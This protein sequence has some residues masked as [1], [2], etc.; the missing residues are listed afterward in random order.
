[1]SVEFVHPVL[2]GKRALP[3]LDISSGYQSSLRSALRDVDIVMGF[4]GAGG[5]AAIDAAIVESSARGALTIA[6]PGPV[7]DYAVAPTSID[8][9][10]QQ[11]MIEVLY[12]AL[13]ETVHLFL[14]GQSIGS[15][16]GAAAFLYP[17]LGDGLQ[18]SEGIV[19]EAAASIRAK[20]AYVDGLRDRIVT[21]A[22]A[23]MAAAEAIHERTRRG[24]TV[25][26]FGNGGSATDAFDLAAEL[27]AS[28]KGYAPVPAF[29]I[30]AEAA[31]VTGIAN[32]VGHEAVFRRQLIAHARAQDVAIAF[33]TS[34]GSPNIAAALVEA[35]TRGLATIAFLGYGGGEIVRRGLAD[36]VVT[37]DSDQIPRVQEA[38]AS[39]YHVM[40]D[41]IGRGA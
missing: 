35:R 34:G 16:P 39:S 4:A 2:A 15:A 23:I 3:A 21:D 29:S 9:F 22:H 8:P 27:R 38:H 26:C 28:S 11:E 19:L 7:G 17:F 14:D 12:H 1:V 31:V 18:N 24:G 37:I 36:H 40:L 5:D 25:W 6:L 41:A 20:A 33:S 10:I 32:D 13:W 30:A